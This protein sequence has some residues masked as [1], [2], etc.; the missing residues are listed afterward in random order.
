V[1]APGAEAVRKREDV[2]T[3]LAVQRPGDRAGVAG[4]RDVHVGHL[5]A[6]QKIS[7]SAAYKPHPRPAIRQRVA[8]R[9]E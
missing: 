2:A 6:E 5:D 3:E 8:R 9:D 1:H 4:D 7:Y